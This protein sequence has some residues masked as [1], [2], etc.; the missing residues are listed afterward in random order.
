MFSGLNSMVNTW[1]INIFNI[2]LTCKI[3]FILLDRYSNLLQNNLFVKNTINRISNREI[4]SSKYCIKILFK[5]FEIIIEYDILK[6][7]EI[8]SKALYNRIL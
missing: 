2:N 8:L 6:H 7:F 1:T 3:A 4:V 5:N